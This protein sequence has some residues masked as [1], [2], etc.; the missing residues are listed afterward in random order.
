MMLCVAALAISTGAASAKP[1]PK[2][3]TI[4]VGT[5]KAKAGTV[6]FA[7]KLAKAKCTTTPG[8]GTPAAHLCVSLPTSPEIEC[9]GPVP[10]QFGVGS[11]ATPVALSAAGTATQKATIASPE[12]LPGS[13]PPPPGTSAFS[14]TFTKKG[15]AT[16]YMEL[17]ITIS[18]GTS[19]LPCTSGKVP[20][21]A[22]LG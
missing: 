13:T 6:A 7:I 15:T 17:N 11:Y 19:M 1:K 5:Y 12:P 16:G 18:F 22:K 21:T 2:P 10:T 3:P 9:T 14:V 4:K 20:F 8:H